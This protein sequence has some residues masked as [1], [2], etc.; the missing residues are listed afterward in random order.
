ML[1]VTRMGELRE[2]LRL[3]AKSARGGLPKSLWETYSAFANTEGGTIVL[4][5]EEGPAGELVPV[6]VE[7]PERLVSDVWNALN[8]PGRVSANVLTGDCVRV[9][10]V[11]GPGGGEARLV[12]I[13]VPRADRAL[14]PVFAGGNPLTG[15]YR[16]NG[17]GDYR[18]GRAEYEAMVRDASPVPLDAAPL[19]GFGLGALC[20]ESVVAYRNALASRRPGHPWLALSDEELLVRLGALGREGGEGPLL[21][22]RA[23]LLMFGHEHEI[24][25]EFPSFFLD[26]RERYEG[27]GGR[28][29]DRVTSSDGERPGNVLGFWQAVSARLTAD[30][31][32]PFSTDAA[33]LRVDDTPMHR[34]LREALVNALIHADYY[35]GRPVTVMKFRDRVEVS[36]PG[37]LRVPAEVALRGGISDAR[38]P[39]LMKMFSLIDA[40]ERAGGGLD[41]IR[42]AC[43]AAHAPEVEL[44]DSH[45]PPSTRLTVHLGDAAALGS[46]AAPAVAA[47]P[48]DEERVLELL[49]RVGEAPRSAVQA[50][51][52]YG[53]TKTKRLLSSMVASGLLRS[54][55]AGNR[56][57]YVL[58]A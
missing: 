55:G 22:T 41:A 11:P 43:A 32:R 31:R 46:P 54:R 25:R 9:E 13:E 28:W 39:T 49:R 50:E 44:A 30:L 57:T 3:E 27:E 38:N 34:A 52:G 4:G 12:V 10:A 5:V 15:T 7:S 42:S 29:S 14:R 36:N 18:C 23:G 58:G 17:E 48:T 20:P 2:G 33:Q 21:A 8:N 35:G 24:V 45:E 51:L 6:G 1:D 26:Y 19:P 16:R 40:C 56:V 53:S 47:P 37:D